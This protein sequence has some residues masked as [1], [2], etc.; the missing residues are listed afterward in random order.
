LQRTALEEDG[1][2]DAGAIFGGEALEVKDATCG[3]W[4]GHKTN[5]I[6]VFARSLSLSGV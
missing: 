6:H 4:D 5:N 3:W 2:A 1:G